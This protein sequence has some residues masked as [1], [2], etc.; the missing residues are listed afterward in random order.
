MWLPS[1]SFPYSVLCRASG[2]V[3]VPKTIALY[4]ERFAGPAE[5]EVY[6]GMAGN[7]VAHQS[8]WLHMVQLSFRT[9]PWSADHTLV[10]CPH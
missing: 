6:P 4:M 2:E 8:K 9:T 3:K 1:L 7:T 10:C 5:L